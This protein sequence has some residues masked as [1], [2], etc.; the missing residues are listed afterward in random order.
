M[1][2]QVRHEDAVSSAHKRWH[3]A[4]ERANTVW[5]SVEQEDGERLAVAALFV[6]DAED[7]GFDKGGWWPFH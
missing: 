2:T 4:I 3:H 1:A 7:G 6:R 5:K